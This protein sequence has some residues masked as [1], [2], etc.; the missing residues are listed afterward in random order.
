MRVCETPARRSS[1]VVC[2]TCDKRRRG[3]FIEAKAWRN[4]VKPSRCSRVFPSA[5]GCRQ[6]EDDDCEGRVRTGEGRVRTG[7]GRV[8]TDDGATV[9]VVVV[10]VVR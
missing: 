2:R 8:R 7:E 10:V 4:G 1:V 3:G 5:M 9:V 6:S